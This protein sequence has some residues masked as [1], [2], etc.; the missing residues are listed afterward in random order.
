MKRISIIV[1]LFFAVLSANAQTFNNPEEVWSDIIEVEQ[2]ILQR[3]VVYDIPGTI[4]VLLPNSEGSYD[5]KL[6]GRKVLKDPK[7]LPEL[8][9]KPTVLYSDIV[10][11]N[12]AANLS[13]LSFAS[14]NM[15]DE[16]EIRFSI[17]ETSY[18]S[19]L[20][21]DIDWDAFDERVATIKSQNPN[22]PNG[23]KFGVVK[24]ASVITIDNQKF[25]RVKNAGKISG[26]GFS[27]DVKHLSESS[28]KRIDFKVGISLSFSDVYLKDLITSNEFTPIDNSGENKNFT[29]IEKPLTK[30]QL[31][32]MYNESIKNKINGLVVTESEQDILNK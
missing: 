31:L 8:I 22:L 11:K 29:E 18:T 23:T 13:Y 30:I 6:I 16:E 25:K 7:K 24:I 10:K 2:S 12:I 27:S 32:K 5:A 3:H 15:S 17:T 9:S 21:N 19:I 28:I 4:V 1:L 26:W 14:V 20:D